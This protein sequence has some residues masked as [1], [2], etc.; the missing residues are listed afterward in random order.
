MRRSTNFVGNKLTA[1][2]TL[3]RKSVIKQELRNAL[4]KLT[5]EPVLGL[6]TSNTNGLG[7]NR[8]KSSS[9]A[10]RTR[11]RLGKRSSCSC[12]CFNI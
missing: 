2:R 12:V 6:T 9:A 3:I 8:T 10:V 7:C 1:T 4:E 5:L 11:R